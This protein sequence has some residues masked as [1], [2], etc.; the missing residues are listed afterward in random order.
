MAIR[1]LLLCLRH[2]IYRLLRS[3]RW[4]KENL[5]S[6]TTLFIEYVG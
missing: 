1:A 4:L 2:N 5:T 3:V 6:P